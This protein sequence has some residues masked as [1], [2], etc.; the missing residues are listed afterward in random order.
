MKD[1]GYGMRDTGCGMRGRPDGI[2]TEILMTEKWSLTSFC[3]QF[4]VIN[5]SAYLICVTVA[6]HQE[7]AVRLDAE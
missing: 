6:S 2:W 5:L 1:E 4:F 3:H 7:P